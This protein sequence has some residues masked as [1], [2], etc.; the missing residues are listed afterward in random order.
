MRGNRAEGERGSRCLGLS[1]G[2][3]TVGGNRQRLTREVGATE[4]HVGVGN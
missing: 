2:G 3:L 1:Q 4:V